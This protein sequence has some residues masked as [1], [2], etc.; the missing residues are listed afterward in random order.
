MRCWHKL[1]G[2]LASYMIWTFHHKLNVTSKKSTICTFT[3]ISISKPVFLKISIM[4]FCIWSAFCLDVF[5]KS[6]SPSLLYKPVDCLSSLCDNKDSIWMLTSS[7]ILA[8]SNLPMVSS[9]QLS[10]FFSSKVHCY[11]IIKI[12]YNFLL[13]ASLFLE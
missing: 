7:H 1:A 9:K 12:S 13:Y 8:T 4:S 3:F 5:L 6:T 2:H 11:F 10:V